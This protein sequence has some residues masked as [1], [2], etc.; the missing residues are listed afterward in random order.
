M[1]AF[2]D[3]IQTSI[4][5]DLERINS[6]FSQNINSI[7]VSEKTLNVTELYDSERLYLLSNTL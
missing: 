4:Q 5:H 7:K 1:G 2:E 6:S 3:R